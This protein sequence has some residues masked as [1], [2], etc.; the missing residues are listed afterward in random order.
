MRSA[1]SRSLSTL[2]VTNLTR[3]IDA[4]R[5]ATSGAREPRERHQGREVML[6]A[7]QQHGRTIDGRRTARIR[8]PG[9]VE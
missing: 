4:E 2:K 6:Y 5:A 3:L 9:R 1:T 8:A 7:R